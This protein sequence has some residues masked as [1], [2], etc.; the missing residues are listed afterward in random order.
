MSF[1]L[2]LGGGGGDGLENG[3]RPMGLKEK[4]GG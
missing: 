3:N 4:L 2:W 1:I